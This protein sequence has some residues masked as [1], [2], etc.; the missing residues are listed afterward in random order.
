MNENIHEKKKFSDAGGGFWGNLRKKAIGRRE[1]N[2]NALS[3]R[4]LTYT[5]IGDKDWYTRV[6]DVM[7][8]P[9]LSWCL[10]HK[11]S[12]LMIFIICFFLSVGLSVKFGRFKLFPGGVEQ[13]IIKITAPV[14]LTLE[15]TER[16]AKVIEVELSSFPKNEIENYTARIGITQKDPNDPFTKRGKNFGM[17]MVYLTP[18]S[19]RKTSTDDIMNRLRS[20]TTWML[21]EEAL[22]ALR[23]KEAI[24]NKSKTEK[25]IIA[26]QD[27]A[28]EIPDQYLDL[29]GIL[30]IY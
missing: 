29:K 7:Y 8:K 18:D 10:H 6:R 3:N 25:E 21:N 27:E 17:L 23:A 16:F 13:F 9:V 1:K 14:G 26:H 4:I 19:M 22:K 15:E 11:Y 28:V 20:R 30:N 5:L 12:T 2:P 24:Q